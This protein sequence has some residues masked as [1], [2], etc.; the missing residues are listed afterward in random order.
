MEVPSYKLN[1]SLRG[2]L[3]QRLLRRVCPE[4]S[5]ERPINDA[6]SHFTGLQPGT[7]VRFATTLSA[8]DKQQRKQEGSLCPQCNGTGYKGRIGTY[9]LMTI[10]SNIRESIKQH[11]TTHEIE[12][13]AIQ[14][15]MLTLKRYG[16]NLIREQLTTISELQKI[17][18]TEN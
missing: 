14:S 15:G 2:V 10:N 3:A 16:I 8:E 17:C 12:Q 13:E 5:V 1:A 11:K 18:N 6:E 9:E 7:P 4:C